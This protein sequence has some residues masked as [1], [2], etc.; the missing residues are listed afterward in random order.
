MVTKKFYLKERHNPQLQ[1]PYYVTY[2]QLT[3]KEVKMKQVGYGE[4]YMLPFDIEEEYLAEIERLKL[5]GFS[6]R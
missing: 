1:K 2:G 5:A 6:V 4:N 3:I